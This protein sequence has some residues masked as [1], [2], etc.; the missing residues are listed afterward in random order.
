MVAVPAARHSQLLVVVVAVAVGAEINGERHSVLLSRSHFGL[1][2]GL[3]VVVAQLVAQRS[4]ASRRCHCAF[5]QGSFVGFQFCKLR[6][7]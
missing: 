6:V 5:K 1:D 3:D 2:L 7:D 4:N